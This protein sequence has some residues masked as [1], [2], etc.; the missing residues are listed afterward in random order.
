MDQP[1]PAAG[2]GK[3]GLLLGGMVLAA[4]LWVLTGPIAASVG[5]SVRSI[6][7]VYAD[8]SPEGSLLEYDDGS[9]EAASF[10][11]ARDSV[12]V[13]V[14]WDMSS[15][16]FLRLYHLENNRSARE[17]LDAIGASTPDAP[18]RKAP[19]FVFP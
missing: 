15:R 10:L 12:T 5:P 6:A 11:G 9:N 7:L 17:A 2:T 13:V 3:A 1:E 18:S 8:E 16:A 19:V 4:L 14:P